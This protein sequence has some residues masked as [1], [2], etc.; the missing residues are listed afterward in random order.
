MAHEVRSGAVDRLKQRVLVADVGGAGCAESAL[1]LR[2]DVGDDVAIEVR[3]YED[4]HALVEIGIRDAS[5]SEQSSIRGFLVF[6][7]GISIAC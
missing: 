2:C 1:V 4:F 3:Q 7:T 6:R 5:P